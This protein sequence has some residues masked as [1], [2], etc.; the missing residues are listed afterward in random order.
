[1]LQSRIDV[2]S[3]LNIFL[4]KS[5]SSC[6]GTRF[7]SSTS[8]HADHAILADFDPCG[9]ACC[10]TA[11]IEVHSDGAL[12]KAVQVNYIHIPADGC[13]PRVSG[14]YVTRYQFYGAVDDS[15]RHRDVDKQICQTLEHPPESNYRRYQT[16]VGIS[17]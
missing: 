6:A 13:Q 15:E 9:A 12:G 14:R 4:H 17:P 2:G 7:P 10:R 16:I 11:R 3:T 1:M 5:A 8:P